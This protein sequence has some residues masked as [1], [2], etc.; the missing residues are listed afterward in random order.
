MVV[1]TLY[2]APVLAVRS[3]TV[4]PERAKYHPREVYRVS[5]TPEIIELYYHKLY[6]P[7]LRPL[8]VVHIRLLK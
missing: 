5:L 3:I 1:Y 7:D 4:P 6:M 8:L 2:S